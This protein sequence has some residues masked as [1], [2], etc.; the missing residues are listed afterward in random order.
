MPKLLLVPMY[1]DALSLDNEQTVASSTAN[2]S[3]LPYNKNAQDFNYENP[4]VS[5]A[6]LSTP[7]QDHTHILPA[8]VHIHWALPASLTTGQFQQK[9]SSSETSTSETSPPDNDSVQGLKFR[10]VPDRWLVIRSNKGGRE[11]SWIV[12]SNYLH[13]VDL[14]EIPDAITFPLLSSPENNPTRFKDNP[15]RYMGR[16]YAVN[17]ENLR[18]SLTGRDDKNYYNHL[19]AL[20]HGDPFFAAF[21]PNCH[22]VFGFHD[23]E[24]LSKDSATYEVYGWYSDNQDDPFKLLKKIQNP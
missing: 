10:D 12:E 18:K 2:F 6:F 8:G 24:V 1:V 20:G 16:A 21:Y 3:E 4:F 22:S 7:F 23:A 19:N 11:K 17:D 5:E 15:F 9:T 14:V 13:P